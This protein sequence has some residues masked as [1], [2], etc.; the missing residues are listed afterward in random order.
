MTTSQTLHTFTLTQQD[1]A[2]ILTAQEYPWSILQVIPTT[3]DTFERTKQITHEKHGGFIAHHDTDRTFLIIHLG[4][5][6][7]DGQHPDRHITITQNNY[8]DFLAAL[9]DT[10]SQAAV[11]YHTNVSSKL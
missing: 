9:Q 1:G 4:S 2:P 3:P 5:G 6:D 7:T 11:W 8:E 10:M